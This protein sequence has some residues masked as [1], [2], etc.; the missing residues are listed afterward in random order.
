MFDSISMFGDCA[1]CPRISRSQ[2]VS[3]PIC[4]S[5]ISIDIDF[6]FWSWPKKQFLSKFSSSSVSSSCSIM[7]SDSSEMYDILFEFSLV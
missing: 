6:K 1:C 5:V 2:F 7:L 4:P 3:I